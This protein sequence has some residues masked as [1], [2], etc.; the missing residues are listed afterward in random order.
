VAAPVVVQKLVDHLPLYREARI[1][2]RQCVE[3]SESTLRDLFTQVANQVTQI[4][5]VHRQKML[6]SG[7]LNVDERRSPHRHN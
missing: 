3:L 6:A 5:E 7:Y 4:Y 1:F 2:E